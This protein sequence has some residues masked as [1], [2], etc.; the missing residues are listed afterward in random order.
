MNKIWL[1]IPRGIIY[2]GIFDNVMTIVRYILVL[3]KSAR[4]RPSNGYARGTCVAFIYP[5]FTGQ[6]ASRK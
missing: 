4:F 5:Y 6:F 3:D 2:Q 1:A